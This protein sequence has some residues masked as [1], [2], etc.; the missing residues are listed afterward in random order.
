MSFSQGWDAGFK[1]ILIY[2]GIVFGWLIFIEGLLPG[3]GVSVP[4]MNVV[5][6]GAAVIFFL[7]RRRFCTA[8]RRAAEAE[9]AAIME[10]E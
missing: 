1:S 9:I 7:R 5:A 2:V 3:P 4:L 6:I 10:N 8:E